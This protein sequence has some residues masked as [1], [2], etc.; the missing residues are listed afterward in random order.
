MQLCVA[1][2]EVAVLIGPIGL[3]WL[4]RRETLV[5]GSETAKPDGDALLSVTLIIFEEHREPD[6]L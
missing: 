1:T 2:F 5:R 3:V 6:L 4:L